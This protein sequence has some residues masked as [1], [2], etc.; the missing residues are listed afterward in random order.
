MGEEEY[1]ATTCQPQGPNPESP[2]H[3]GPLD[4]SSSLPGGEGSPPE[5]VLC[6]G[7]G[8]GHEPDAGRGAHFPPHTY[9]HIPEGQTAEEGTFEGRCCR[10]TSQLWR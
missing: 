7:W 8:L 5:T 10:L 3:G 6:G 1:R 2:P 9:A 4:A